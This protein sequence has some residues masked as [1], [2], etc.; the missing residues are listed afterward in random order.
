MTQLRHSFSHP[1][2]PFLTAA[3]IQPGKLY[4]LCN[5][6][7]EARELHREL[8]NNELLGKLSHSMIAPMVLGRAV[9][10]FY[11]QKEEVRFSTCL[12]KVL[13]DMSVSHYFEAAPLGSKGTIQ[14]AAEIFSDLR[15]R[16][17]LWVE[18]Y[19]G[20]VNW[21]RGDFGNPHSCYWSERPGAKQL[22][23]SLFHDDVACAFRVYSKQGHGPKHPDNE[24]VRGYGRMWGMV[25]KD[26]ICLFNA[27]PG[28]HLFDTYS[29]AI[30]KLLGMKATRRFNAYNYDEQSRADHDL[31]YVNNETS[32]ALYPEEH[33]VDEVACLPDLNVRWYVDT[34]ARCD[35]CGYTSHLNRMIFDW[36]S[37]TWECR[38]C[39]NRYDDLDDD[40]DDVNDYD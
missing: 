28:S 20:P 3:G 1:I 39:N 34:S 35:S 7:V 8:Q 19:T 33:D 23:E 10:S 38:D 40:V 27:Y 17:Q 26:Y 2:S 14:K 15:G 12:R 16:T 25:W 30:A 37:N 36:R 9:D 4:P 5:E 21:N 18:V 31:L 13:S 11:H 32:C 6:Q 29:N 24:D 22:I